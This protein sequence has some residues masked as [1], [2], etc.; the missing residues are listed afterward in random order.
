VNVAARLEGLAKPGGVCISGMV[1]EGIRDRIDIPFEDL[2]EQEVKN[3][4]RPV[5]V[6]QWPA[7]SESAVKPSAAALALPDKPSIAVLPFDNM[8]S[9]PEHEYF[10][11]G[12]SE[13]IITALSKISRMRIIARNSTFAYK[14]Q[15]LDLRRVASELGVR[16]VLE[17]SVRSSGNR[18]RIT[19]Q[20]I[21]ANDGSH[22]WAERFDRTIDD[23]FDIQDEI[24]KEIVTALRVK[25]TDGEEAHILAR[26]TND[27]EAWQLCVRAAE[28][29]IRFN[30]TDYLE[31][32]VLAERAV[33]RDPNYAYAWATLGLTYWFDSRL[34]Y[35]GETEAK[36]VRANE[37]AERAMALDET[38]SWAIGLSVHVTGSQ[39]REHESV[40]I[41]RRGFELNPGNADVRAFLAISLTRVGKF[42]EA[43]GHYRAAISLNPFYPNWYR[44]SLA[45]NL[46]ILD[47]FDEAL[48]LLDEIQS[49]EPAHIS[50]WINKAYMFGQIGRSGD[51]EEAIRK[52][53]QLAPNLRLEHAPGILSI[54]DET[55]TKRFIDGLRKAGFPE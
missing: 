33:E 49:T 36:L 45:R 22:I 26:G 39:G 12:I 9:D 14:G 32:R 7:K 13:D 46:M 21:D 47:E 23:I 17:G 48:V 54:N 55:A 20:L 31:A 28:L 34:G 53:K 15:A 1:Y 4:D 3:I 52:I 18:L 10:A 16:Y 24:T 38:V 44:N 40:A 6:F 8:S 5:R 19:A 51:A 11:D 37:C 43:M 41:A 35:T 27:I 2:G 42:H 30:S 50:S 29:F 25:L